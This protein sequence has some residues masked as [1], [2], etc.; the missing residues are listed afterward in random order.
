MSTALKPAITPSGPQP[1]PVPTQ[2]NKQMPT[3]NASTYGQN[4]THLTQN[5]VSLTQTTQ[6]NVHSQTN[7]SNHYSLNVPN[8]AQHLANTTNQSNFSISTTLPSV[9]PTYANNTE[10]SLLST[11]QNVSCSPEKPQSNGTPDTPHT[12]TAITTTNTTVTVTT[13][14]N[15]QQNHITQ[16]SEKTSTQH[17]PPTEIN[18][19]EKP[20]VTA[21]DQNHTKDNKQELPPLVS[22]SSTSECNNISEDKES[23][24]DSLPQVEEKEV[25][26]M[27]ADSV[28]VTPTNTEES[29]PTKREQ[30][31]GLY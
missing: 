17:I 10:T 4:S 14:S 27:E 24:T 19:D 6:S 15:L 31:S 30:V 7:H 2:I 11:T 16:D 22:L 26:K 9:T 28:D 1:A 21:N 13:N 8:A 20:P 3:Q 29:T 23:V 18:K 5:F 12:T 25:T